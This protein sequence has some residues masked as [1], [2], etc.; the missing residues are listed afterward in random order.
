M[1]ATVRSQHELPIVV[2]STGLVSRRSS[3]LICIGVLLAGL[4]TSLEP[5]PI[6]FSQASSIRQNGQ[7]TTGIVIKQPARQSQTTAQSIASLRQITGLTWEQIASLFGVS[8]QA[9]HAWASGAPLNPSNEKHLQNLSDLIGKID[10]GTV[11]ANRSMLEQHFDGQTVLELL[12]LKAYGRVST[13]VGIE[14]KPSRPSLPISRAARVLKTP[15]KPEELVGALQDR[16]PEGPKTYRT[17]QS[18]RVKR[19]GNPTG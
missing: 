7:T 17:R 18:V 13:L 1:N 8:R 16:I 9:I 14:V 4:S 15:A 19:S 3:P 10:R 2:T 5:A 11:R 12:T 6:D